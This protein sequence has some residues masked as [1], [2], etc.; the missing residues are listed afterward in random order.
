MSRPSIA[1]AGVLILIATGFLAAAC[2]SGSDTPQGGASK[3]AGD[4][5]TQT[6]ET[7][8]VTVD[9]TWLTAASLG[10][11]D[12]DLSDYPIDRFAAVE[13][14]FTTHSGDLNKIGMEDAATLRVGTEMARPETWLSVSDDSHH[15]QGVLVFERNA[16]PGSIELLLDLQD[17]GTVSLRWQIMPGT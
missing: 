10:D 3:D 8:G 5:L 7:G 13:I 4:Q 9:A 2:S 14:A 17:S 6:A 1:V 16:Q 12:A 11:V 15:R